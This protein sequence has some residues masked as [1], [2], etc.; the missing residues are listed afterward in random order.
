M[1]SQLL[2]QL[3]PSLVGSLYGRGVLAAGGV[4]TVHCLKRWLAYAVP[5][6][7]EAATTN[8]LSP[9]YAEKD[10]GDAH[11]E[12]EQVNLMDFAH[13]NAIWGNP[14]VRYRSSYPDSVWNL[15]KG[16]YSYRV[17]ASAIDVGCGTGRGSIELAKRGFRVTSVEDDPHLLAKTAVS[18][19]EA[20]VS[21]TTLAANKCATNLPNQCSDLVT[22][23]HGLHHMDAV[24]AIQEIHRI[25]KQDG[26]FVAAW[27]D[28]DLS[29]SFVQ[30]LEDLVE[31]S[32]LSYSRY[33]KQR[34]PGIW[35]EVLSGGGLFRLVDY[36]VHPNPI[37]MKN[38]NQLVDLLDSMSFIRV[39]L[40]G[41]ERKAF[42][43]QL[44][45]LVQK[46]YGRGEFTLPLETKLYVMQ[47]KLAKQ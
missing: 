8:P 1:L 17:L 4:G 9:T 31:A 7:E 11:V 16:M 5:L 26:M 13:P 30:E 45:A 12:D 41:N 35:A 21:V 29:N 36:S 19:E 39:Y 33:H 47:K 18:A 46:H 14:L 42:N 20:G 28:R 22:V 10:V 23:M 44:R 34:D 24:K 27:N 38:S 43:N 37:P 3:S 40:R 32:N 15:I 25:L 6:A 2:G